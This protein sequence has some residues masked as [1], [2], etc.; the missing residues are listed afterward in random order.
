VPGRAGRLHPIGRH[1]VRR[2]GAHP[3]RVQ[4]ARAL[5]LNLLAVLRA[6]FVL[7]RRLVGRRAPW[8]HL[9]LRHR[10]VAVPR[11]RPFWA[12]W[13]PGAGQA[14][15]TPLPLLLELADAIEKDPAVQGVLVEIPQLVAGWAVLSDVREVLGRLRRAGKRVVAYLPDGGGHREIYLATACDR[16]LVGRHATLMLSGLASVRRYARPLLERL[17]VELEV[18][19]RAEYK[20][21]VEPLVEE[22]MSNPQREQTQ[23]LLDAVERELRHALGDRPGFDDTRIDALFARVLLTA[24]EAVAEGLVDAA[25]HDDEVGEALEPRPG[26]S[27]P[28]MVRAGPYLARSS[29]PLFVPFVLPRVVAV[30]PVVGTIGEVGPPGGASRD[31]LVPT[32]RRLAGDARV[33]AVV[34]YVDSPGGSALASERIHRE[35]ERLGAHKP[36]VACFGEVA[37]SGGYYIAA[38][39]HAIVARPQTITGSIGVVSARLVATELLSAVGLRTEVVKKSPSADYLANPRAGTPEERAILERSIQAF[40]DRFLDVVGKGRH[41]TRDAV[42]ELARGRVWSGAD[43]HRHGLVDRL[44][45]LR[46]ALEDAR[47]RAGAPRLEPALS[48]PSGGDEGAIPAPGEGPRKAAEAVLGVLHPELAELAS[49]VSERGERVLALATDLPRIE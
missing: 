47:T 16:V 48:W 38:A 7:L 19:R 5:V 29:A 2:A 3:A 23:A 15:P 45:G 14:A 37:A 39:A 12:R 17:G 24:E 20:T 27:A 46:E 9:R 22:R 34:L 49:L 35:V 42:H 26:A 25:V 43:A 8:V 31:Q 41:M 40:Y 44:G 6:P 30:V 36:V 10:I 33:G 32:L 4:L 11:P 18:H 1:D 13:V 28:R 21:A